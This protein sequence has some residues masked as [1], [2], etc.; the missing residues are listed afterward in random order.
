MGR[1]LRMKANTSERIGYMRTVV[2]A[3]KR[4]GVKP[5]R[6]MVRYLTVLERIKSWNRKEALA[7][8]KL[9]RYLSMKKRYARKLGQGGKEDGKE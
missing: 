9:K 7:K 4:L 5:P 3:T 2:A 8:G 6:A 1:E